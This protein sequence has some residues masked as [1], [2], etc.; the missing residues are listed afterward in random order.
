MIFFIII[1]HSHTHTQTFTFFFHSKV[2]SGGEGEAAKKLENNCFSMMDGV[3]VCAKNYK[4]S[5]M[6]H[7][8]A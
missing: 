4:L 1:R 6:M 3:W 7:T 2:V 5:W 8:F